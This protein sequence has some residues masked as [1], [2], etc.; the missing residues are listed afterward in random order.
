MRRQ[1]LSL[2][3]SVTVYLWA[4]LVVK[5]KRRRHPGKQRPCQGIMK[6]VARLKICSSSKN[7]KQ[8]SVKRQQKLTNGKKRD[9]RERVVLRQRQRQ[10][11]SKSAGNV[12][13][14]LPVRNAFVA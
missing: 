1:T 12:G 3:I 13:R 9:E 14:L 10:I 7:A 5:R 8:F 11:S 4:I 2:E 6:N